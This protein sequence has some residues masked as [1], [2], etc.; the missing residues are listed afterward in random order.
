M[1]IWKET[2]HPGHNFFSEVEKMICSK[3]LEKF[4][5]VS[6]NF[7]NFLQTQECESIMKENRILIHVEIGNILF[8]DENS[9]EIIY[10]FMEAQ[11]DYENCGNLVVIMVVILKHIFHY[12]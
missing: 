4:D 3:K 10:S 8:D 7:A 1:N 5:L 11:Q 12:I 9:Q 2:K 6:L